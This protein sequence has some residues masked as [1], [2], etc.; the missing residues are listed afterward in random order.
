MINKTYWKQ[1]PVLTNPDEIEKVIHKEGFVSHDINYELL[2]L[3]HSKNSSC[4][5]ISMG[6]AGHAYVFAE[7]AYLIYKEGFDVFIMP[8]HGGL[9]ISELLARH[10]DALTYLQKKYKK[11]NIYSEG[12]GGLTVFYLGLK[13]E[14]LNSMIFENSPAL[15]TEKAFHDAMKRGGKAGKRRA[16]LLP[17]FK[18]LVRIFPNMPI[19][20]KAYLAWHEVIDMDTKNYEKEIKLVSAYDHDPDFDKRYPLRAVMSLVNTPP[21]GKLEDIQTLILFIYAKKGLIPTYIKELFS[22]L[23]TQQK[24]LVEIDGGVFWMLSNP[25][26]AANIIIKWLHKVS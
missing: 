3:K 20:I 6:S 25:D 22:R 19:P 24:E 9:T 23:K 7:L 16:F 21:P 13:G 14:E 8:K 10:E 11:I 15:L 4:L 12:L 2:A 18:I 1:Y 17:I 26:K 5:L